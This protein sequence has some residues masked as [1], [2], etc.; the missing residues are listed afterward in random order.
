[1]VDTHNVF[2]FNQS[3]IHMRYTIDDLIDRASIIQL[4]FERTKNLED[5]GRW[6]NEIR[7]YSQ[8]IGIYI[9]EGVCTREQV[10]EWFSELYKANAKVWDLESQVRNGKDGRLSLEKVGKYAVEIKGRNKE[11]IQI[12]NKIIEVTGQGYKEIKVDHASE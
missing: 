12:K 1:M 3:E 11:R 4:K 8:A 6:I 7:G 9:G 5:R 10:K 2:K